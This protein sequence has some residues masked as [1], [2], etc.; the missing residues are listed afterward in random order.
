MHDIGF[1]TGALAKDDVFRGIRLQQDIGARA[2]EISALRFEEL[3]LTT[4][5]IDAICNEIESIRQISF[6]APSYFPKGTEREVVERIIKNIPESWPVV[7]HPDAIEDFALWQQFGDRLCIEN[8]DQ[9]KKCGRTLAELVGVFE[10]LPKAKFCFDI[11]HCHQVDPTMT[12]SIMIL[13]AFKDRLALVH[14]SEVNHL[15][16][17]VPLSYASFGA[18]QYVKEFLPQDCP[19]IIESVL[20]PEDIKREFHRVSQC[21]ESHAVKKAHPKSQR[22]LS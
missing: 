6:H 3:A 14:V 16:Q 15:S 11:G 10:K 12:E 21:F 8:M 2:I 5:Q 1:S 7:V 9:R 22:Q 19:L 4:S 17:H 20:L 18:F 13:K